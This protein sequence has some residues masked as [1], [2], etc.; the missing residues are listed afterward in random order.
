MEPHDSGSVHGFDTEMD[1]ATFWSTVHMEW[2]GAWF[3][4]RSGTWA[5]IIFDHT[6]RMGRQFCVYGFV[7]GRHGNDGQ[8]DGRGICGKAFLYQGG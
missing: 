7:K 6:R 3:G 5:R 1:G 4:E 8:H 2:T